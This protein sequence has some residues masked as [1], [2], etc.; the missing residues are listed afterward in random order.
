MSKCRWCAYWVE[1]CTYTSE[2]T[3]ETCN[4]TPR[5]P[6]QQSN[7]GLAKWHTKKCKAASKKGGKGVEQIG[8]K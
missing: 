6:K 4:Y 3:V 5:D 7:K 8:I 1:G 2:P